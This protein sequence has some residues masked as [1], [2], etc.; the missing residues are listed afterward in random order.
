[1]SDQHRT[2]LAG[3]AALITGGSR[4]LG[5]EIARAFV[6]AGASIMLCARD[7]EALEAAASTLRPEEQERQLVRWRSVDVSDPTQVAAVVDQSIHDFGAL[8][9]LVNNAAVHGPFGLIEHVDWPAWK[10]AIEIN[11]FGSVNAVRAVLPHFKTQGHGKI[12]Q[13]SGGGAT[14]PLPRISAYAASKAAAVRFAETVAEE[15]RAF[16]IDV[17]SIAPGSLNT[18]MLD[19]VLAAGSTQVGL[20]FFERAFRQK[21]EGGD[22]PMHAT[23]LAVFLASSASDGITG[24]L[25]SAIW[26]NWPAWTDH[27][28]DLRR[29][30]SYTLRRIVGRDR[31]FEW[32][33]K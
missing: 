28:D 11:L 4:G 31:G 9:V 3:R 15:C 18:A 21:Q 2:S 14:K 6:A 23:E 10:H 5:L 19:N 33:D 25:I 22:S 8:H 13:V 20:E 30:D 29:S 12:I 16:G 27:L 7:R 17:N 26:D 24:K 1:M 32:G